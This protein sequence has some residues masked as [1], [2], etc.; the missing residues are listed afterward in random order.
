MSDVREDVDGQAGPPPEVANPSLLR[1]PF[2]YLGSIAIGPSHHSAFPVGLNPRILGR[3]LGGRQCKGR[4]SVRCLR[5][6]ASRRRHA[7]ARQS[8]D[9]RS[10]WSIKIWRNRSLPYFVG[11]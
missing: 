10:Q 3:F 2:I 11:V 8:A 6:Y 9:H 7:R 4:G 1:P 5:A